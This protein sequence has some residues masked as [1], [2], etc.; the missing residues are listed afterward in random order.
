ME[1]CT[2]FDG[3]NIECL[4]CTDANDIRLRIRKDAHSDFLQ[5]FYFRLIG[6]KGQSCRLVIE[7]ADQASY[8]DGYVNYQTVVSNGETSVDDDHWMRTTTE[9]NGKELI[10]THTPQSDSTYFSYFAPYSWQRH[11][12][13]VDKSL[14]S[15]LVRH[16]KLGNTLD[17]RVLDMLQVGEASRNKKTAWLIARQ[18]PG[19]TMAEWWMEGFVNRLLDNNDPGA[20]QALSAYTFYIVPNMNPDGSVRGHLRTNAAGKNLNRAWLE[21]SQEETPEVFNVRNKMQETGVDFC[22]D[23]HGD[24]ALPYNFI[25]GAQGIPSW[26]GKKQ[27]QLDEFQNYL[28]KINTDFQTEKG[29][30]LSPPGKANLTLC[31]NYVAEHFGCLAMTL[32]MP[33][34][35]TADSPMPEK[36]WSPVRCKRLAES[37]MDAICH[38]LPLL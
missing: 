2:D 7:N 1:I 5:W 20:R 37:C 3:A 18:H 35:D 34:K 27:Q 14:L 36:G 17:G 8:G 4:S 24:E 28:A 26:N 38:V 25:A 13:L 19:E 23:V 31:T 22:F 16:H 30:P 9:F 32:E 11:R 6:A 33:F 29:Y 15:P 12:Q 10:I 21:P